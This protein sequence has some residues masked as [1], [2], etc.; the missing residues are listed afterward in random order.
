MASTA[1]DTAK[2]QSLYTSSNKGMNRNKL[3]AFVGTGDFRSWT[4]GLSSLPVISPIIPNVSCILLLSWLNHCL[5]LSQLMV[6][7]GAYES[8]RSIHA[9]PVLGNLVE[10]R[11]GS[12]SYIC[13]HRLNAAEILSH[14]Y[15]TNVNLVFP[16]PGEYT[17]VNS[18]RKYWEISYQVLD[19][20]TAKD[21][22]FQNCSLAFRL[23]WSLNILAIRSWK[24][25]GTLS[26]SLRIP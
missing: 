2:M 21:E 6:C 4:V 12:P 3:Q 18:R 14:N 20:K 26:K 15:Q 11:T 17:F 9:A 13:F 5:F 24:G 1:S 19:K 10:Q 25:H 16:I 22:L 23:G 8:K 7:N